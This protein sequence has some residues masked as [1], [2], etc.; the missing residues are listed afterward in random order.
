MKVLLWIIGIVAIF[1]GLYEVF[2]DPSTSTD[3]KKELLAMSE[4]EFREAMGTTSAVAMLSGAVLVGVTIVLAIAA[5][6]YRARTVRLAVAACVTTI[7]AIV[8]F[9]VAGSALTMTREMALEHGTNSANGSLPG[10]IVSFFVAWAAIS[11]AM[12]QQPEPASV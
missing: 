3:G 2:G 8:I 7:S 4:T 6:R 5:F 1:F 12:A 11:T 9:L 10:V